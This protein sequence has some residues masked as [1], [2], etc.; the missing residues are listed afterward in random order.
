MNY[1]TK[2]NHD[3]ADGKKDTE[4]S[5]QYLDKGTNMFK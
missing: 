3:E 4:N 5:L 2:S 1:F